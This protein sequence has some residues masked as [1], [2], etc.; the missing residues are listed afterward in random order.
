MERQDTTLVE[1]DVASKATMGPK[2][3]PQDQFAGQD[4]P[5]LTDD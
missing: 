2:G 5:G 4:R 1:L 3:E